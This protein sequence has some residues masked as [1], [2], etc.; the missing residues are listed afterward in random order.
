MPEDLAKQSQKVRDVSSK[1][2]G[3][4]LGLISADARQAAHGV[5]SRT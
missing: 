3:C 5:E 1:H 2:D 4:R